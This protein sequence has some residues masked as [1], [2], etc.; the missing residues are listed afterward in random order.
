MKAKDYRNQN[1]LSFCLL[2][3]RVNEKFQ[4]SVI[5]VPA[6]HSPKTTEQFFLIKWRRVNR[7]DKKF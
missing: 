3:T 7:K 2:Q 6:S 1:K 5:L 4:A